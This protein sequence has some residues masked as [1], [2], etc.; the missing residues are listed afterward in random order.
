MTESRTP[1]LAPPPVPLR[2]E[3]LVLRPITLDDLDALRYYTDPEVCRYLPFPPADEAALAARVAMMTE[4]L[5]PSEP[6]D[7]L[8]LAVVHDDT[9]VGDLILRLRSRADDQSPPAVAEIGW[10]FAPP[11]SGR[12]YA[13]EA[14]A[15]LIT[16]AFD[17]YPLHR[18]YAN[19]DPLN[20]RSAALCERL[21]MTRE[22]H[23]RRDFPTPDGT[24]A[25]SV[26]YGLLRE[27]WPPVP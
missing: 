10:A 23:T 25:D 24:W 22:A 17:H 27:E 13:T 9:L 7:V 4:R 26:I 5:A 3:R 1:R 12:G 8:S 2:T 14:A 19:L 18:V 15:A 11:Y 21:G 20:E 16:M 6:D